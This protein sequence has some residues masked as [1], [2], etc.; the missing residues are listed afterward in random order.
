MARI[1]RL[2][3]DGPTLS[4]EFF[5]PK[6]DKGVESLNEAADA[7][8]KLDPSFV[9]VTYGGGGSTRD[10]TRDVVQSMN[11]RLAFPAMPHLTCVGQSR[12]E[13]RALLE[14]Y[15]AAGIDNVLALAGDPPADGSPSVGDFTYATEL[16]ELVRSVGDFSIG[17]AAFPEL[18]PRSVDRADDRRRL[19][20]KLSLA[21]YGIT[22]FFFEVKPYL[23]MVHE[24]SLLGCDKPLLPGVMP[25]VNVA[26]VRRMAAM[27]STQ[28]PDELQRRLDEV[29]GNPEATRALGVE[30]AAELI[31]KLREAGV[32][33]LHLYAMNRADSILAID[34]LVDLSA[35]R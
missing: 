2:F 27:N 3:T 25:F 30:V 23:R 6:T 5:P 34:R 14:T 11:E 33:G 19:A 28:I 13:L 16:I 12:S 21:D 18:H 1:D 10:R 15:R 8:A 9:S 35:H 20:H 24:L 17:V 31:V 26:G 22:Q 4:F 7:L 29:D 32:P